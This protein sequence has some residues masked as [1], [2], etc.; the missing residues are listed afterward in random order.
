MKKTLALTFLM[1][2]LLALVLM[3][4][5]RPGGSASAEESSPSL[6][7]VDTSPSGNVLSALC[8]AAPALCRDAMS[9]TGVSAS[10]W[11]PTIIFTN[12]PVDARAV[13]TY[14][15]VSATFNQNLD[16]STVNSSTFRISQAG[17]AV[18]GSVSYITVSRAAVFHPSIPLT[19]DSPYTAT[20]TTGV[21][22][23]SGVPMSEDM[24]WNFTT[25]DGTSPL[26]NGMHIYIG[27]LHSHSGYSDGQGAPA[28]AYATAR[29]NGL[30]FFALTDHSSLLTE[31][32]WQ[33][34]LDQAN[35]TSI[36][37]QFVGLRGFEFS[38]PKGHI[39]VFDTDTMVREDDPAYDTLPEFYAWLAA[40]P[41]A[42]GQFNHPYKGAGLDWNFG[43]FAYD[44]AADEKMCLRETNVYPSDQYLL[45]LDAGWH[46]GAIDNSDTH[47]PD[48]GRWRYMG[49]VA[50]SLTREAVLEALR[51]RRTFSMYSWNFALVMQA[52]GSWMGSGI[53]NTATIN[54][55]VIAYDPDPDPTEPVLTLVL[56]DNGV[57]VRATTPLS[58]SALYIWT[59]SVAGSPGH[60]YYVKAYRDV[61]GWSMPAYTS[62]V[63]TDDSEIPSWIIHIPSI[64]SG[65]SHDW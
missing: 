45:G 18:V 53:S 3:V 31:E 11:T 27:D 13:P 47:G 2:G 35:A 37:G 55:T 65:L 52:N 58:Q 32:E 46:L 40:Q 38:H 30:D 20:V 50:P 36:D 15:L 42:I 59:P 51:D 44:V 22:N 29:A 16:P 7:T 28:D 62:P 12:P 49:I 4:M 48:W 5:V 60:Y 43:D 8:E 61:G 64:M 54:F 57:P 6:V 39:N 9:P 17:A 63:W 56:Y 1:N 21:R 25:T 14:T 10:S 41:T 33:D 19:P 34:T 23:L 24:V 26:G